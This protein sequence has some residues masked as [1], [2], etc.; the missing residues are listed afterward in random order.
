MMMYLVNESEMTRTEFVDFLC[1]YIEEN[2]LADKL[3]NILPQYS[4]A[5]NVN[6]HPVRIAREIGFEVVTL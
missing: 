3:G 1:D 4:V 6:H 2:D 5:R